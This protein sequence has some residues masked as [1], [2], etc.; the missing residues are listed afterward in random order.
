MEQCKMDRISELTRISRER[1]LTQEET[2]E[3]KALREEYLSE[4]RLGAKQTLDS[5][6]IIDEKGK[7]RKLTK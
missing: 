3:R 2:C 7:K 6:Y 1:E 5:V 4:W